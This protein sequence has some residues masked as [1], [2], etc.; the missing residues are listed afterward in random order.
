M[1]DQEYIRK[2]FEQD[3]L[4]APE[5]LSEER[6]LQMLRRAG[7]DAADLNAAASAAESTGPASAAGSTGPASSGSILRNH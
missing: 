3:G 4:Q 7:Q 5:S 2:K 6:M 1:N